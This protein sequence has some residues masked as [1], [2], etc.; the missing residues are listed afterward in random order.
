MALKLIILIIM[1]GIYLK[2]LPYFNVFTQKLY[3]Y[4]LFLFSI[5][6]LILVISEEELTLAVKIWAVVLPF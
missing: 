5:F 4:L 1:N 2:E 6:Y 3:G